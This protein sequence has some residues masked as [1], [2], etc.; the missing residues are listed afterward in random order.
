MSKKKSANAEI[1]AGD[2]DRLTDICRKLRTFCD[3]L[4][5]CANEAPII[6]GGHMAEL[7]EYPLDEL[8]A[9]A[10]DLDKRHSAGRRQAEVPA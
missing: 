2:L 3:M 6:D 9:F 5:Y 4:A 8:E 1:E 10:A 7:M